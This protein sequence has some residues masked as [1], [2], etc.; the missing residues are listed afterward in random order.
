MSVE[1][2][3][4]II[5]NLRHIT[6]PSVEHIYVGGTFAQIASTLGLQNKLNHLVPYYGFT[7]LDLDH[8]LVRG[9][10][11]Q[12]YFRINEYKI[13]I[14]NEVVQHFYLSNSERTNVKNRE[15]WIYDLEEQGETPFNPATPTYTRVSPFT[16]LK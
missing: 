7:L 12:V 13:L 3:T 9:M 16:P 15:K 14:D 11:R 1:P 2:D 10:G 5:K 8:S 6:L 4:F